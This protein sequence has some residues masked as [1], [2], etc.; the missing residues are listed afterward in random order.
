MR[1]CKGKRGTQHDVDV[2]GRAGNG[3]C[4]ACKSLYQQSRRD[5]QTEWDRSSRGK[6]LHSVYRTRYKIK[7][8]RARKLAQLE[9]LGNE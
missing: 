4:A 7:Q 6:A 9:E 8:R 5:K 2:V 1:F 3:Q